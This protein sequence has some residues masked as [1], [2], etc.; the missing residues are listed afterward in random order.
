[1]GVQGAGLKPLS[2][3]LFSCRDWLCGWC[4]FHGFTVTC[5]ASAQAPVCSLRKA[6]QLTL[7]PFR[8]FPL[9]RRGHLQLNTSQPHSARFH[10]TSA[11]G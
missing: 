3:V 1:M 4:S 5:A 8:M 10:R 2:L 9:R 7:T 6:G 11:L